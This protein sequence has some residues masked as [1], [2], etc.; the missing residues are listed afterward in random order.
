MEGLPGDVEST[1]LCFGTCCILLGF[2]KV[3][4]LCFGVSSRHESVE[5]H[6]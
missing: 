1:V 2:P 3:R 4:S 5:G 6:V